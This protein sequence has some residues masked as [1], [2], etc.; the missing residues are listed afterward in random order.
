MSDANLRRVMKDNLKRG[1]W[2]PIETG[3]TM[4]G[5]PDTEFAFPGGITGWVECKATNGLRIPKSKSLPFQIAWHERRERVQANT[6]IAVRRIDRDRFDEFW[7]FRGAHIRLL[8]ER[9]LEDCGPLIVCDRGP[10]NWDWPRIEELLCTDWYFIRRP[11]KR[12]LEFSR[13]T[14]YPFLR[15]T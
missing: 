1:M 2:T 14:E 13:K 7:L 9:R 10:R 5:V 3:S 8:S 12:S 4:A 15:K 11:K 6:F